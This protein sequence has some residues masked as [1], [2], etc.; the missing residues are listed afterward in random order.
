MAVVLVDEDA[1]DVSQMVLAAKYG[2]WSEAYVILNKK[3]YLV[4]CIPEDRTWAAL[5]QSA[6]WQDESAVRKLLSYPACDSLVKTKGG[7]NESGAN[8]TAAWV[9]RNVKHNESIAV[10]LDEFTNS[11]REK[12]FAGHI[13]TYVTYQDGEEMDRKGLPLLLV[14]LANYKRTFHPDNVA[15]HTA[16]LALAKEVF[17]HVAETTHW[18][19]ARNKVSSSLTAFDISAAMSLSSVTEEKKF[20]T[21]IMKLYTGNHVYREVNQSLRRQG[22]SDYKATADDL[23]L[24]PYTLLADVLLFYWPELQPVSATTY[25][26]QNLSQNDLT[27]YSVGTRFIWLNFVSSSQDESVVGSFGSTIF[28]IT[29]NSPDASLWR[30]RDVAFLSEYPNEK[31]ALY[32]AGCE[33]KVMDKY[34]QSGKTRIKLNLLKAA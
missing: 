22:K 14:T 7:K 21:A 3:P 6:W 1:K 15:P 8:K 4:N 5:H 27:R 20:F 18:R 12:R 25:R 33:Y 23:A 28:E 29:N 10:I 19:E 26:G 32:P 13:P 34:V 2:R 16:F 17:E 31:E 24:G 11:E 30:P 9:A